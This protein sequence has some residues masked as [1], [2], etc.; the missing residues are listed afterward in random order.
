MKDFQTNTHQPLTTLSKTFT[1][2]VKPVAVKAPLKEAVKVKKSVAVP[3]PKKNGASVTT[4]TVKEL[5]PVAIKTKVKNI[6]VTQP[7]PE[8]D[9]N[10]YFD[11][12]KK[13]KVTIDFK[14]VLR[15]E[16]IT[17]TEFRKYKINLYDFAGVVF[18][19][20]NAID[21]FFKL[22]VDLRV[23]MPQ[24]TKYYCMTEATA[25]YLQKYILY[26]KR[27]VFFGDGTIK[28]LVDAIRK[29]ITAPEKIVVPCADAH[30]ADLAEAMA[31]YKIDF[32]EAMIFR[33]VPETLTQKELNAYDMVLL[34]SPIAVQALQNVP[35]FKQGN[36]R[37]G[38]F[39]PQSTKAVE[40]AGLRLD[41]KA[42]VEGATSM[43]TAVDLYLA[44]NN[45]S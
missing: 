24:E 8:G 4:V 19:S 1:K 16:G 23:N 10:P 35:N 45:K 41:V 2:K 12:A 30:K 37:I 38:A 14:P 36:M 29:H 34:F 5:K 25:L 33:T 3:A 13:H 42:P 7:K 39:G 43:S 17:A 20:R 22:S 31:K 18:T 11:L 21:Q 6:L 40:D 15:L 32:R 28:G 26:R 27:K 44:K 9:K